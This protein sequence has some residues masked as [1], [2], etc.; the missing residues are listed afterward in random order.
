MQDYNES[1]WTEDKLIHQYRCQ[2]NILNN[3][4]K[5]PKANLEKVGEEL[6]QIQLA[7]TDRFI[8]SVKTFN[9]LTGVAR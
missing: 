3:P 9:I 6:F 4:E 8:G 1:F 7:M 2:M 5:F